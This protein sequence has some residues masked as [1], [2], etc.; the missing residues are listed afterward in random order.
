VQNFVS[1]DSL[2]TQVDT[3]GEFR[4][5]GFIPCIYFLEKPNSPPLLGILILSLVV[6]EER[7]EEKRERRRREDGKGFLKKALETC[8]SS[9]DHELGAS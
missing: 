6:V 8:R 9:F 5:V 7:R 4:L 1:V 2:G 3:R